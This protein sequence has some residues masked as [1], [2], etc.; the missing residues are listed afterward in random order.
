MA[1]K[2]SLVRRFFELLEANADDRW[3]VPSL[4]RDEIHNDDLESFHGNEDE[5]HEDSKTYSSAYEGMTFRD[6]AD[7]GTEG[8]VAES[9]GGSVHGEFP[10]EAE[11]ERFEDRLRFLAAVARLWRSAARPELWPPH[12]SI[13]AAALAEWMKTARRNLVRLRELIDR[14]Y[15]VEV[16]EPTSGVEGVMEFDRRRVLKGHLLDLTVSTAVETTAAA[17]ALA[18]VL[19]RTAE[20]PA[21]ETPTEKSQ[22]RETSSVQMVEQPLSEAAWETVA[23]RLERAI[24]QADVTSARKLVS[25]FVVL[26]RNEPLLVH[27]PGDGGPP[28]PAL[29]AQTALQFLESLLARLPRLGL[30][31]ETYQLTKL[32]R[33]MER[34]DPPEGKRVSSFDQLFRTAVV[35]VVDALVASATEWGPEADSRIRTKGGIPPQEEGEDGPLA[36]AL[37]QIAES[38]HRLWLEHSQTLRLSALEAVLSDDDW[39]ELKEFIKTYGSDLFTVRF[40]TLSNVRG[41]IGQGVT[42]WLDRQTDPDTAGNFSAG[43]TTPKLLDAWAEGRL[44]RSVTA[45]HLE[46]VLQSLVEHYDEYRDYNT[47]TTQSDYGENLYILLDFL[48]LKVAYERYAWRL[49][50]LTLAHE[51]LCRRGH[52]ALAASWREFIAGKTHGLA[53]E[54]LTKLTA[55]EIEHGIR[56]RTVRDRLEERFVQPLQ[57]DQAAARV[58]RAATAAKE[59]AGATNPPPESH[60]A[61]VGLVAAIQPLAESPTGV[62]LDVPA[63][64]RRLEDELRRFRTGLDET[65]SHDD[66]LLLPPGPPLDF[67]E[68][69]RQLNEWERPLGE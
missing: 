31:R 4:G 53:D 32:A 16:P 50:P 45:K 55:R 22:T 69:K 67:A 43:E 57:I 5:T 13:S 46:V 59:M 39:E 24:A 29:R 33:A 6:S 65:D 15:A 1:D 68:L 2:G 36:P 58:A 38:F 54:L 14:M 21:A 61:F 66:E 7:D 11:A 12:D 25:A 10:L 20:L 3:L 51:V 34:N 48:R 27:P 37:R 44:D 60:P 23:I 30:L 64:L 47:T 62:G 41:I 40:L 17:R 9:G 8:A 49:R 26:F 42:A 35:A 56:V 63:W 18:A 52:D 28:A 19:S